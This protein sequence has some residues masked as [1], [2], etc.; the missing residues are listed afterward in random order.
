MWG[1][2]GWSGGRVGAWRGKEGV[3]E[4][5]RSVVGNNALVGDWERERKGE[6]RWLGWAACEVQVQVPVPVPMQAG[7]A[8]GLES[9][10]RR[11]GLGVALFSAELLASQ[12][13]NLAIGV[14][15][16]SRQPWMGCAGAEAQNPQGKTSERMKP[17][18]R[19]CFAP[20]QMSA[21]PNVINLTVALMMNV[22]GGEW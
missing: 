19:V 7:G 12:G 13:W 21:S 2:A 5:S 15:Q 14:K 18:T 10:H 4:R 8:G 1:T 20:F 16:G 6:R 17:S 9:R 3:K 11:L 22:L